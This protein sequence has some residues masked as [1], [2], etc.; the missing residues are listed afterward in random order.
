MKTLEKKI[1]AEAH[2]G[3]ASAA[4]SGSHQGHT[5]KGS[6]SSDIVPQQ[7]E[8]ATAEVMATK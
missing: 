8:P 2:Q 1:D 7:A 5:S 4:A 3:K 6:Q